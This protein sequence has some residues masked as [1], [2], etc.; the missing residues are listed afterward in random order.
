MPKVFT[1]F[2]QLRSAAQ[3]R[4]SLASF[5]TVMGVDQA[6]ILAQC[7]GHSSSLI[8]VPRSLCTP[9]SQSR[10]SLIAGAIGLTVVPTG[11][12][13]HPRYMPAVMEAVS[14]A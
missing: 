10:W 7:H 3:C 12:Q 2:L 6:L 11:H 8:S 14:I 1:E 5:V 4:S 9:G 13:H